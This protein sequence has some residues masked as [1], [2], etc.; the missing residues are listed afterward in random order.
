MK[1]KMTGLDFTEAMVNK[2]N[3]NLKNTG[4]ENIKFVQGDIEN[5]PLADDSLDVVIIVD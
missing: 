5:M 4:F 3:E 1:I 2:A